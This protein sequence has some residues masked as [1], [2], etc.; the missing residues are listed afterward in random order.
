MSPAVD[1]L[2]PWC[3]HSCQ[4]HCPVL[5]LGPSFRISLSQQFCGQESQPGDLCQESS[6]LCWDGQSHRQTG[7][8][9]WRAVLGRDESGPGCFSRMFLQ[10]FLAGFV[11]VL[12]AEPLLGPS[13]CSVD[14]ETMSA[15][16]SLP[17]SIQPLGRLFGPC[18]VSFRANCRMR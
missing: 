3:G 8:E 11:P 15:F 10:Q 16:A 5:S 12:P 6:A 2:W 4:G 18:S 14:I 17:L 13:L 1:V 7:A 9:V